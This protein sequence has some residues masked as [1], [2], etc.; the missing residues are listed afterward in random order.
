MNE[1][2]RDVVLE[3]KNEEIT[4]ALNKNILFKEYTNT[5]DLKDTFINI[6]SDYSIESGK[7]KNNISLF[8]VLKK[9]LKGE[10][11]CTRFLIIFK[12]SNDAN[13]NKIKINDIIKNIIKEKYETITGVCLFV[14]IYSIILL[15][16]PDTKN[17]FNLLHDMANIKYISE[18]KILYFSEL[19][20]QKINEDFY[21]FE[22][23]K[24]DQKGIPTECNFV[25]EVWDLYI[26][27]LNLCCYIK[28]NGQKDI[29][30][31]NENL[32][33]N[34]STLPN[35]YTT[36]ANEYIWKIDEFFSFF[37][38]DFSLPINSFTDDFL[39]F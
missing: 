1:K 11:G 28:D 18:L 13:E 15:E 35:F 37:T 31:K 39:D 32:K 38:S 4:T 7:E 20:K 2:A 29:F 19:N 30:E 23:K 26:N 5:N 16:S 24:D 12:I 21:F 17:L 34:F 9:K 25:D 22:Y 10:K 8:N 27:I 3:K 14:S 6:K 33:K 36:I